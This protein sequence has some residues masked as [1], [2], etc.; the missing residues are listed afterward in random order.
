MTYL[1]Q[2]EIHHFLKRYFTSNGCSL[3]EDEMEKLSVQL[4]IEM[5][6]ELMNRPFYWHYLEKTGGTPRPMSLTFLTRGQ[7]NDP[8]EKGEV[9]HFGAPRLHQIFH[10]ARNKGRM[11]KLYEEIPGLVRSAPLYPWLVLNI[12]VSCQAHQRKD[13]IFSFGLQLINGQI[14]ENFMSKLSDKTI[15]SSIPD[16]TFTMAALIK[17]ETGIQRIKKIVLQD[18]QMQEHKWAEEAVERMNADL[19]LLEKFYENNEDKPA[20]YEAEREAIK[21]QYSPSISIT[22]INGGLFYLQ[23]QFF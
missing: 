14:V 8:K 2:H 15:H 23:D 12:K 3:V 7:K 11:T 22:I 18:I 17:P 20:S 1:Q 10:S 4:N 21:M 16:L 13:K 5:D 9:I 6:K 19:D